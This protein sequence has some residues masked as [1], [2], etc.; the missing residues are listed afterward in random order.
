MRLILILLFF[1]VF[2]SCQNDASKNTQSQKSISV[3]PVE[4][5][6][7]IVYINNLRMRSGP[8]V[9]HEIIASLPENTI[10]K[11]QGKSSM[12]TTPIKM[13][14]M[15]MNARWL[16]VKT[17]DGKEG[18]LYGGGIKPKT[19]DD[20][21]AIKILDAM[22]VNGLF[23]K[24]LAQKIEDYQEQW[25]TLS[26]SADF[27]KNY[28]FGENI[29]E[30]INDILEKKVEIDNPSILPDMG[31][32]ERTMIGYQNSLVAEGTKFYLFQNYKLMHQKAMRTE[33]KEDDEFFELQ[34]KI[35]DLDSIEH[36]YKSWFM[37]TWDYG[38]HSL[39]GA[40]KHF[41]ILS[42]M[43]TLFSKSKLFEKP[44]LKLKN[45]LLK[46][47][48][49]EHITYWESKDKILD[50]LG[51]IINAKFVLLSK[52]DIIGLKARKKMFENPTANKIEINKRQG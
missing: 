39:L 18:W 51:N 36:F 29:Q 9:D 44:I 48:I 52:E 10:V 33:G 37:Q 31:W 20:I 43:N 16:L 8:N 41:E 19:N 23:E 3:D 15:E 46:D 7:L 22:Q 32:L 1:I 47:I 21:Q 2:S 28:L 45:D 42:D 26:T 13:R 6:E 30:D 17:E 12:H 4:E 34:F 5:V 27:A 49:D 25:N 14:G 24:K 11:Y 40:G 50:E 35:N 38:G